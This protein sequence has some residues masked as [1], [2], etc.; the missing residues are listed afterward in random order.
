M[1]SKR[2]V[3]SRSRKK[4]KRVYG[5]APEYILEFGKYGSIKITTKQ[6]PYQR[7][8]SKPQV[9][10]GQN[11]NLSSIF[12]I[13]WLDLNYMV[14]RITNGLRLVEIPDD[15]KTSTSKQ[16]TNIVKPTLV[17]DKHQYTFSDISLG[18]SEEIRIHI[19]DKLQISHGYS[20]KTT[21]TLNPSTLVERGNEPNPSNNPLLAKEKKKENELRQA[22]NADILDREELERSKIT[23]LKAAELN[24]KLIKLEAEMAAKKQEHV[25]N[26]QQIS[27]QI[28]SE[29]VDTAYQEIAKRTDTAQIRIIRELED[30]IDKIKKDLKDLYISKRNLPIGGKTRKSRK[31]R[32]H[33]RHPKQ[34]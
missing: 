3:D 11:D 12:F 13:S 10:F 22:Q 21:E 17:K 20:R 9:L 15:K 23:E 34:I 14:S 25:A 27:N 4:T 26:V 1:R 28:A 29:T 6:T 5:G 2:H 7:Q 33:H 31:R 30:E 8:T 24:A 19:L 16:I 32:L 18:I